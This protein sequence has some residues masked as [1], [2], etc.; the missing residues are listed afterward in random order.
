MSTTEPG[1]GPTR[2]AVVGASGWIGRALVRH[3]A[4]G[5]RSVLAMSR[6]EISD[7]PTGVRWL[8][9]EPRSEVKQISDALTGSD[10]VINVAGAAHMPSDG[11]ASHADARF[12]NE[13]LP[14]IIAEA[15]RQAGI[16]RLVHLSSIKAAGEGG[17]EPLR[18]ESDPRP[19]TAYGRSK[20]A[21][22]RAAV[23]TTADGH[24]QL[25]IVR[26]PMVYGPG[27][28]ANFARLAKAA[29]SPLPVPLPAP[30]PTRSVVFVGNL[31]SLLA[32]LAASPAAAVIHVVD[33]P[34][35]TTRVLVSHLSQAAGRRDRVV[36]LPLQVLRP[37]ARVSGRQDDIV[38]LG[39][40]LIVEPSPT[41]DTAGWRPPFPRHAGFYV[42]ATP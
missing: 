11:S 31:V 23:E 38:R 32:H 40:D 26:P 6:R 16:P 4:D 18:A 29:G 33:E 7:S 2:V 15:A 17:E 5:H 10:A 37:I 8:A 30:Y 39:S 14:A 13:A 41:S 34:N 25:T 9:L 28:P 21:G 36:P 35:L 12:A 3:L 27:A 22:E 20:L 42:S 19:T 1:S 24:V